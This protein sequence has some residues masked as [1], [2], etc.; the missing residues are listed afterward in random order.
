MERRRRRRTGGCWLLLLLG[1]IGVDCIDIRMDS[2][3]YG[4]VGESVKLWCGFSS[5]DSTS[6]LINVDWSYR[7]SA[8]G[9]TV[10]IMHYQSK[11]YPTL[12]GPFKDRVKW[13]GNIGHGD[14]SILLED[15]KLTDNGTFTCLVKN[16]PDVHGKVP[17][18]KLTVTLQSV[19][20]KFNTVILLSSLVFIPSGL[21]SVILLIR[22]KKAIQRDRIR[23]QKLKKSPIEESQDC[24]YDAN[25]TTP[26]HRSSSTEK[27]PGCLMRLC[28]RCADDYDYD[29]GGDSKSLV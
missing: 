16:P 4:V 27:P 2:E 14:A 11:P 26:L 6:E 15:L 25:M 12:G 7:S 9:P 18:T 10:T 5:S 20:F 17:Q 24:V 28:Q 3:V 8:G 1:F 21:V 22:M 19:F 29:Y 23:S 13:E